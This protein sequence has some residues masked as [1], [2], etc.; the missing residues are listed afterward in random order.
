MVENSSIKLHVNGVSFKQYKT[1][2]RIV[3]NT[4]KPQNGCYIKKNIKRIVFLLIYLFAIYLIL[5]L[6]NFLDMSVN[7]RDWKLLINHV[8]LGFFIGIIFFA[9]IIRLNAHY[10]LKNFWR[11]S[12]LAKEGYELTL[13]IEVYKIKYGKKYSINN[14]ETIVQRLFYADEIWLLIYENKYFIWVHDTDLVQTNQ[15]DE[16][17]KRLGLTLS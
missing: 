4:E 14:Y 11:N 1:L 16:A 7:D 10:T 15:A 6:S 17:R 9:V 13:D 2:A 12:S 3:G 5:N 8:L